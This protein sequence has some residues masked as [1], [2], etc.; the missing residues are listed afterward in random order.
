MGDHFGSTPV[1]IDSAALI[2]ERPAGDVESDSNVI[3]AGIA[4]LTTAYML[5]FLPDRL[6]GWT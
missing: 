1:R 2:P 5:R 6:V 4:G 3:S